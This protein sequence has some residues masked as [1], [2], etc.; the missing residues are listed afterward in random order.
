[1]FLVF[2]LSMRKTNW[3]T[4]VGIATGYGLD[5]IGIAVRVPVWVRVCPLDV[6]QT[7]FGAQLAPC[8][9]GSGGFF[10]GVSD[11]VVKLTTHHQLLPWSRIR[12]LYIQS[13][14]RLHCLVLSYL[15]PGATFLL[16]NQP[17]AGT[18]RCDDLVIIHQEGTHPAELGRLCSSVDEPEGVSV[19]A[20]IV[21]RSDSRAVLKHRGSSTL[22]EYLWHCVDGG[23][24]RLR[25]I[26]MPAGK[27]CWTPQGMAIDEYGTLVKGK[28]THVTGRG[29]L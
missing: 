14:I 26:L 22:E 23:F 13:P 3:E 5:G 25:P 29:G 6:V 15:G 2:F 11:Q 4:S 28:T 17:P 19:T 21:D 12:D 8:P 10:C 24:L 20:C 1:M 18:D 27:G 9:F 16:C 7:G